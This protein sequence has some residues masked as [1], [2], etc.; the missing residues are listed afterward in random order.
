VDFYD[1]FYSTPAVADGTVYVG[2]TGEQKLYAFSAATG[3][4]RWFFQTSGQVQA[5]PTVAGGGVYVSSDQLD[6]VSAST[7]LKLWS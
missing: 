1:Q 5:A 2:S 4:V 7:H 6:A 3:K